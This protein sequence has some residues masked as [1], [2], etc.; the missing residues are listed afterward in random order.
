LEHRYASNDQWFI[1]GLSYCSLL[2][3]ICTFELIDY[4]ARRCTVPNLKSFAFGLYIEST[5]LSLRRRRCHRRR[6]ARAAAA[7]G[8]GGGCVT[9]TAAHV[10]VCGGGAA[11][12]AAGV[13]G[14]GSTDVG[15][16]T[17][18]PGPESG[19]CPALRLADGCPV[20]PPPHSAEH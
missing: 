1:I 18:P 14:G 15:G 16:A 3:S 5:R 8:V 12:A 9:P 2:L 10:G 7:V 11:A 4:C 17:L 20:A 6:C 13:G 19:H